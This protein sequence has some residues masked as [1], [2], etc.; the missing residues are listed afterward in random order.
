MSKTDPGHQHTP[1]YTPRP[2]YA[3]LYISPAYIFY[4]PP[5]TERHPTTHDIQDSTHTIVHIPKDTQA[6]DTT[7]YTNTPIL[8]ALETLTDM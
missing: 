7:T 6:S 1:T 5:H 2:R 8:P 3:L 4:T